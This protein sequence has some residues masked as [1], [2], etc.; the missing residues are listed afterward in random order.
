MPSPAT[1]KE[2]AQPQVYRASEKIKNDKRRRFRYDKREE[3]F[4]GERARL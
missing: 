3:G 1:A 4:R 2:N